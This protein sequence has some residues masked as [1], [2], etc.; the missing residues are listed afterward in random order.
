MACLYLRACRVSRDRGQ[1]RFAPG[2]AADPSIVRARLCQPRPLLLS[3]PGEPIFRGFVPDPGPNA[4]TGETAGQPGPCG[5]SSLRSA[6]PC[7]VAPPPDAFPEA[8]AL[9]WC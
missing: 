3:L 2:A 1:L 7:R 8:P 9:A 4:R 6:G 5:Y